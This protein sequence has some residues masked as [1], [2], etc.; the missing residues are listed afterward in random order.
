MGKYNNDDEFWLICPNCV[1]VLKFSKNKNYQNK[2]GK[3][4]YLDQGIVMGIYGEKPPLMR[5]RKELQLSEARQYWQKLVKEGWQ[6]TEPK[7]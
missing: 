1:E 2:L 6:P 7:W 5:N 4:M 3:S